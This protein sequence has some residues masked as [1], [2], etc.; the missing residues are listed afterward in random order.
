MMLITIRSVVVLAGP[1]R[2]EKAEHLP[3]R[4]RRLNSSTAVKLPK[5][6]VTC[7]MTSASGDILHLLICPR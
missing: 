3:V 2:A 6:F 7:S 1:V 5:R 4:T